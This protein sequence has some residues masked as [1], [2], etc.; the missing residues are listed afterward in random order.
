[1]FVVYD[2]IEL[3][4]SVNGILVAEC[5]KRIVSPIP[6]F[7]SRNKF[8]RFKVIGFLL[9][10]PTDWYHPTDGLCRAVSVTEDRTCK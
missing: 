10:I 9:Y 4:N 2:I 7:V 6:N 5:W 1:M 8:D 3:V